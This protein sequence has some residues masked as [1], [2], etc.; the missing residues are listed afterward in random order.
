MLWHIGNTTVR[1]PYRLQEA[2]RVLLASPFNGN[3]WLN[4]DIHVLLFRRFDLF[5]MS[6]PEL[7]PE[8]KMGD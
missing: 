4:Q 2:L 1:T 3:H 6:S 8:E 5:W 7:R